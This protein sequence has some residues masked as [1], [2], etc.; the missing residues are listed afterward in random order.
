MEI[1]KRNLITQNKKAKKP[2]KILPHNLFTR[3]YGKNPRKDNRERVIKN[4]RKKI[5]FIFRINRC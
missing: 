3:M 4:M 1:N 5:V 2:Y